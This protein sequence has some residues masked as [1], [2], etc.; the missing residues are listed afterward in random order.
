MYSF[1]DIEWVLQQT[2]RRSMKIDQ[3]D[4][5]AAITNHGLDFSVAFLSSTP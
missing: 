4:N 3:G 2:L 5:L 1:D